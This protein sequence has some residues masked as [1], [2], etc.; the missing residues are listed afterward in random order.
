[1]D[2]QEQVDWPQASQKKLWDLDQSLIILNISSYLPY[3]ATSATTDNWIAADI[4]WES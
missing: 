3:L 2:V 4:I 1:M